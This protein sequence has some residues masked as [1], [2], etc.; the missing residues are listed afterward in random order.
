MVCDHHRGQHPSEPLNSHEE[1]NLV[2]HHEPIG[3]CPP[4]KPSLTSAAGLTGAV[5]PR[6]TYLGR[7]LLVRRLVG[8]CRRP[9]PQSSVAVGSAEATHP[10][11]SLSDASSS[12]AIL[13]G[14]STN[15]VINR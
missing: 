2:M 8:A 10:E 11:E 5:E 6:T 15:L 3:S 7:Y 13:Q 9:N 12:V 1:R 4:L 14:F